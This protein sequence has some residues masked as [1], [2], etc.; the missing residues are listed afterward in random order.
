MEIGFQITRTNAIYVL[1]LLHEYA[2]RIICYV[3]ETICSS[4]LFMNNILMLTSTFTATS[5]FCG[6]NFVLPE[7]SI[8]FVYIYHLKNQCGHIMQKSYGRLHQK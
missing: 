5:N 3:I 2:S 4:F 7:L 8:G 6:K 1:K